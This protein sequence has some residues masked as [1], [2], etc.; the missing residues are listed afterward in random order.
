MCLC[1]L[2]DVW[3]MFVCVFDAAHI[4][5]QKSENPSLMPPPPIPF[6]P[7]PHLM[8]VLALQL[9]DITSRL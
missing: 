7:F 6:P 3:I 1:V 2:K 4:L 5:E 8:M 9:C